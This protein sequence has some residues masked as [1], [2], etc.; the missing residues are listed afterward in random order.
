MTGSVS[1]QPV[2]HS[3]NAL[4]SASMDVA[5]AGDVGA[6]PS[7][8]GI[9]PDARPCSSG[10]LFEL[11]ALLAELFHKDKVHARKARDAAEQSARAAV[12][13][14]VDAMKDQANKQLLSGLV[15]GAGQIAGGV[16]T[17]L[18]GAN[19]DGGLLFE[20][21]IANEPG[22]GDI[23][24]FYCAMAGAGFGGVGQAGSA[25]YGS[26]ATNAG[27][28]VTREQAASEAAGRAAGQAQEAASNA[29]QALRQV[30]DRLA[31]TIATEE[32]CRRAA[33]VKG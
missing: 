15:G 21:P 26:E 2:T 9:L 7:N 27:G 1:F 13:R 31:E 24:R 16:C 4:S 32:A 17:G 5:A 14:A 29:H 6:L 23:G 3:A 28:Q 10:S 30:L 11:Q 25:Y 19:G 18:G 33:L 20:A 12:E 8:E 22:S